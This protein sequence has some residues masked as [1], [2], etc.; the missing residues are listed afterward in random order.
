EGLALQGVIWAPGA[1][2]D[3]A[4]NPVV[5]AGNVALLTDT[6]DAAGRHLLR[7]RL[8][9]DISNLLESPSWPVL[10]ANLVQLRGSFLPRLS[11]SSIRLGEEVTLTLADPSR[12]VHLIAPDKT[13]R[14]LNVQESRVIARG[15]QIG[16]YE[17]RQ[18]DEKYLFAVNALSHEE[19]DLSK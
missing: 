10:L 7:M 4:G 9:H 16:I 17:I 5:L 18:G 11:R 2:G 15:E 14:R 3:L 1:K 6:E 12:E 13:D 19:S 8:R